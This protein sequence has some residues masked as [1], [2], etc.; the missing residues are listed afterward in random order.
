M[1]PFLRFDKNITTVL[2]ITSQYDCE[3]VPTAGSEA[4]VSVPRFKLRRRGG[5]DK[6]FGFP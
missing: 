3:G 2:Y 6:G 5:A 1:M 4:T